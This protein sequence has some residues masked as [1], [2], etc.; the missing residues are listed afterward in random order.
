MAIDGSG[1]SGIF[2]FFFPSTFPQISSARETAIPARDF[3]SHIIRRIVFP[4]SVEFSMSIK[5][6]GQE[7]CGR[8]GKEKFK[9]AEPPQNQKWKFPNKKKLI[10]KKIKIWIKWRNSNPST[11]IQFQIWRVIGICPLRMGTLKRNMATRGERLKLA[12]NSQGALGGWGGGVGGGKIRKGRSQAPCSL[13]LQGFDIAGENRAA[14][15]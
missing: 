11:K 12:P 13:F 2:R 15:E 10:L 5:T 7:E 6:A 14:M 4:F 1:P 3:F 9:T 8:T